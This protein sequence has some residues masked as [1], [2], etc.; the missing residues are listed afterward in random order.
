IS[1][2]AF[3]SAL[4]DKSQFPFFYRMVPNELSQ[5]IGM[6]LLLV[7]FGWKWIGLIAPD[8]EDGIKFTR[9]ISQ[10]MGKINACIESII[11]LPDYC[12][13]EAEPMNKLSTKLSKLSSN[14]TVVHGE[15]DK[16]ILLNLALSE[17]QI[18]GK[19]WIITAVWDFTSHFSKKPWNLTAFHGAISLG[20][21][22]HEIPGFQDFLSSIDPQQYS[23][24]FYLKNFW[25]QVFKCSWPFYML[26]PAWPKCNGTEKL[27]DVSIDQ[28]NMKTSSLSYSISN[29]VYAIAHILHKI[30]SFHSKKKRNARVE[31][32]DIQAWQLHPFL[33]K[34]RFNNC[35]GEE[36]FFDE[37]ADLHSGYDILN[38]VILP[39]NTPVATQ[40]GSLEN[41]DAMD[42]TIT[43]NDEAVVWNNR[44]SQVNYFIH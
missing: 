20:V 3:D 31:L 18:G 34:V 2:G 19:V 30:Y 41:L 29:A 26:D 16:L 22:K 43:I 15:T 10:E 12:Q 17:K 39:N 25:A 21:P 27:K 4:S 38:W 42:P 35:V 40:L 24:D 32:L 28:F 44:Y 5:F 23:N 33:R 6:G 9:V 8:N 36:V 14:V 13:F 11:L 1:Y 7:H 37:N